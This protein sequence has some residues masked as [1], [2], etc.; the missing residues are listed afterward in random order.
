MRAHSDEWAFAAT[1]TRML[2]EEVA[3][4]G[5]A[6]VPGIVGVGAEV[7]LADCRMIEMR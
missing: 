6:V 5:V 3:L 2:H 7:P 4:A 1:P